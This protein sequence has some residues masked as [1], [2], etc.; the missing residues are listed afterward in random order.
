MML[1]NFGMKCVAPLGREK[2]MTFLL[3]FEK[4]A[5]SFVDFMQTE[6]AYSALIFMVIFTVTRF[7]RRFSPALNFALWV[8]VFLR[9]VLPTDISQPFSARQI[10][11]NG[12]FSKWMFVDALMPLSDSEKAADTSVHEA[13]A[14]GLSTEGNGSDPILSFVNAVKWQT[15]LFVLW[16]IGVCA[17][18]FFY[19]RQLRTF[20]NLIRG[21]IPVA[22]ANL[23]AYCDDWRQRLHIKRKVQLLSSGEFLSP[24]TIG[25]FRPIIFI[26]QKLFE[27]A[28]AKTVQ[29]II[30]HE[31][32][33]IKRLDDLWLRVQN[34]VQILY[35]FNPVVWIAASELNQERERLCDE[36]VLAEG[37]ISRKT[38]GESM[39]QILKFNLFGFDGIT[40]LPGFGNE[41]KRFKNRLTSIL[42]NQKK[43][44]T[45]MIS[46]ALVFLSSATF[47]LP[48]A[49]YE[50]PAERPVTVTN[51][52]MSLAPDEL[53]SALNFR[54]PLHGEGLITARFG[55]LKT[56]Y[57]E[58]ARF[59]KAVD[60]KAQMGT[61]VYAA[62]AG[63]VIAA[64]TEYTLNK[65]WGRKI[66]IKHR[67]GY[68]TRYAH[69]KH[70]NVQVGQEVKADEQIGTV[71]TTGQSTGPHLHF[72]IL[73]NGENLNPELYVGFKQKL[74]KKA[75][76]QYVINKRIKVQFQKP[77]QGKLTSA[78][79][80]GKDPFAKKQRKHRGIDIAQ[81]DGT[82][83]LTAAPGTVSKLVLNYEKGEGAGMV[84]EITHDDGFVSRYTHLGEILVQVDQDVKAGAQIATVGNTGRST[85]PHVHFELELNGAFVDPLILINRKSVVPKR[86]Q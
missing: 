46:I 47:L 70:V 35:F 13:P 25:L 26:P 5:V 33:H 80:A 29:A 16:L 64:N 66:E 55:K 38:Y 22:D 28:G 62:E 58:A 49:K 52:L 73:Q 30:A 79:G 19:I 72:E 42:K 23:A 60:I 27:R 84:V 24:F 71:G 31:M 7:T 69:L 86:A 41:K 61:P 32:V 53:S 39:L 45:S 54:D 8:L 78:F 44:R 81:K 36:R 68:I 1:G 9:L 3:Q 10:V 51:H 2:M 67:N 18:S 17:L 76:E 48:M 85:G 15:L 4:L 12:R 40:L 34:V 43:V 74:S 82:P 75:N 56:P 37:A 57:S 77:V 65:G 6:V 14:A 20:R 59:H 83:V 63:E 11:D 50:T 21:A